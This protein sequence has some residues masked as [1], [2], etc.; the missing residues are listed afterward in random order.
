MDLV[1]AGRA[2]HEGFA[3]LGCH[4]PG[5]R[6]LAVAG[7]CEV[8]QPG[9]VLHLHLAAVLAQLAPVPLEPGDDL[10]YGA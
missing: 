4:E 7:V 8:D 6:W 1:V 3:S 5:P 9:D 2:N 10:G